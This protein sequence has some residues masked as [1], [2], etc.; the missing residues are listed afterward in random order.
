MK[1]GARLKTHH[2]GQTLEK[3]NAADTCPKEI[4]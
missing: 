1:R 2:E 4:V 3:F